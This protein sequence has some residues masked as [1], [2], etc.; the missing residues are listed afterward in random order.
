MLACYMLTVCVTPLSLSTCALAPRAC[1]LLVCVRAQGD[2]DAGHLLPLNVTSMDLFDVCKDGLILCKLI[3]CAQAD[4]I[5]MRCVHTGL[6]KP[7]S[8]F[9][10]SE[11]SYFPYFPLP[12]V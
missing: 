3:N 12:C 10:V 1:S 5:D 2:A 11:P 6:H 7:L 4:T 8:V 9:E